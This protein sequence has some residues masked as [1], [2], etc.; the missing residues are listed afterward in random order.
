MSAAAARVREVAWRSP[1]GRMREA[2]RLTVTAEGFVAEGRIARGTADGPPLRVRYR[3]EGDAA[4]RTR[5]VAARAEEEPSAL[6]L[7]AD[8]A[9]R[10]TD[11]DGRPLDALAGCLDVDIQASP[12]TN[13]LPIRRLALAPGGAAEVAAVFVTVPALD[14]RPLRQRYTRLDAGAGRYRYESLE[15]DFRAELPVD[16]DGLLIA[17]PGF[18]VRALTA[19]PAG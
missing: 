18:F 6:V 7:H 1:D 3:I 14:A 15:S 5:R 12:F 11:G 8:G 4:W 10:W 17:Y 13:T 16:A 9:G 2:V 19:P